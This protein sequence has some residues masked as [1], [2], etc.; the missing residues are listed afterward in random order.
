LQAADDN[1][2]TAERTA[3]LDIAPGDVLL[4]QP[5]DRLA[6]R[7]ELRRTAVRQ[8]LPADALDQRRPVRGTIDGCRLAAAKEPADLIDPAAGRGRVKLQVHGRFRRPDA[9]R[10]WWNGSSK[11]RDRHRLA[12]SK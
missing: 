12:S 8:F 4:P 10:G 2:R 9:R 5:V 3:G 1:R 11:R 6:D 7:F